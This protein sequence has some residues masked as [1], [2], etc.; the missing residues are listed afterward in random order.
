MKPQ[1]ESIKLNV[2]RAIFIYQLQSMCN[3]TL[4]GHISHAHTHFIALLCVWQSWLAIRTIY[5]VVCLPT[6]CNLIYDVCKQTCAS[7][8]D[9]RCV[10][11]NYSFKRYC[12]NNIARAYSIFSSWLDIY[13]ELMDDIY[14][15][16]I[17]WI[18]ND[19]VEINIRKAHLAGILYHEMTMSLQ[20]KVLPTQIL[21]FLTM[22][23]G[24]SHTSP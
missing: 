1:L 3:K 17:E 14:T 7:R 10:Y 19:N 11:V 18:S 4:Y 23:V 13:S 21:L 16:H 22:T 2:L 5:I 12:Y 8:Y 20:S 6:Q 9:T 15:I 24:V